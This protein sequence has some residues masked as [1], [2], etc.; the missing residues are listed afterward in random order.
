MAENKA[1]K[2]G[3]PLTKSQVYQEL[4]DST[5][6]TRKQIAEVFNGLTRLIKRELGKKGPGVFAIPGLLKL[7][8]TRKPATKAGTRPDPFHKGEIMNVKAKPAR[9]VVKARPLKTLNEMV[10]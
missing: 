2:A 6:L 5:E 7:R 1:T 3:K 8:L 9:N 10:K 4:A